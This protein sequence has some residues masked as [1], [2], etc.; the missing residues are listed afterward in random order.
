MTDARELTGQWDYSTL[1]SNV[2]IGEGCYLEGRGSFNRFRSKHDPGLV[3]G[4]RVKVYNWAALSVEPEGYLEVGD[5]S[6]LVGPV[7]W[8]GHRIIIGRRVIISYNVMI[9]D[10]DFHPKDP[11]L[12]RADAI[13]VSPNGDANLRPPIEYRP[14]VIEDDVR[15][16]IGAIILK[17]VTVGAGANIWPG[18]VV[19][20]DVPAGATIAGNPA[21]AVEA[22]AFS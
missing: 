13:A 3:L 21:R 18:A 9:A 16:G 19:S 6:T 17:G 7:F 1:P 5:D 11:V 22:E 4:H 2:R 14:V 12:R 15:I 10:G 20:R 8:C